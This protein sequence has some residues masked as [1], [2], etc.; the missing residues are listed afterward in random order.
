MAG[1]DQH[2]V[3]MCELLRARFAQARYRQGISDDGKSDASRSRE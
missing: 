1:G 2:H 3:G